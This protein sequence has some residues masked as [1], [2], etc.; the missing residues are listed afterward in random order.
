MKKSSLFTLFVGAI[1]VVIVAEVMV[2]GYLKTPASLNGKKDGA[3]NVLQ[4]PSAAVLTGAQK[5]SASQQAIPQQAG[6][7]SVGSISA[8][9]LQKAGLEKYVLRVAP[10]AGKLLDKIDFPALNSV[11][12]FES[13]LMKNDVV[14]MA[15]FYEFDA[16]SAQA[17]QEVYDLM[18]L[19]CAAEVGAILNET[20]SF[21]DASFYLNYYESPERVF[22]VFR[23]GLKIFA[24][25]YVKELHG[26]VGKLIGLL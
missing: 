14:Q 6:D 9:L 15:S 24:F 2:D 22:V 12:V 4:T 21:G 17:T 19:K 26:A 20:N 23:K 25:T 10:Y 11:P 18:K 1:L 7:A 16:S 5:Q 8:A 13:H 3:A